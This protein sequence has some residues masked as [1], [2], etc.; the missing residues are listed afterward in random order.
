VNLL[1]LC[2]VAVP[3]ALHADGTPFGI[4]LL[5]PAGADALVASIARQFQADSGLLPGSIRQC[6]SR[7]P[8]QGN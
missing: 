7:R 5:A 2:G 1:G 3:G 4:T 8:G 6:Q